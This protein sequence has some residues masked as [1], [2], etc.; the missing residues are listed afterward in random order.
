[1]KIQK[2]RRFNK[3]DYPDAPE[4]M[5]PIFQVLNMQ[6]ERLVTLFQNN[7]TFED[8]FR[9]EIVTLDVT[10]NEETPIRLNVLKRN[11]IGILFLGSNYPEYPQFTWELADEPLTVNVKVKWDVPPDQEVRATFLFVGG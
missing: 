7:V 3:A 8:N 4:W 6:F 9:S 5:E 2:A 11:P 10:N 1:M